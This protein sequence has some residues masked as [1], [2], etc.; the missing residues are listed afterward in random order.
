MATGSCVKILS[1][2]DGDGQYEKTSVFADEL[3]FPTGIMPWRKGA[4]IAAAPDIIYAEDTDGDGRADVQTVLFTGFTPGNQ[5]HRFNGFEWGL[6]GWIYVANGDSGGNV[7][8]VKTGQTVSINGRDVRFRPDTGEVETVSAMTQYGLRRDDWG[9]WFGND[10]PV[11]LWHVTLPE[12]YLKRNPK[13]AVKRVKQP[14]A[15]YEN[16]TRVFPVSQAMERPNQPWSL[17]H[18]TSACSPSPYRDDLFGNA[19]SDSVFIGEPVHN[20][21]H[22]EVLL[23]HGSG[24]R[25]HRASG[26]EAKE[27]LASTDNWFRPVFLRTGP[28]GALWVADFYRFVLEHPEWISA[29]MQSRMDLRAGSDKG[30][31]YRISPVGAE[32][33]RT[34]NLAGM[35]T[36]ALARAINSSNGWQR[37]MAQ[38]L[39]LERNDAA[40]LGPLAEMLAPTC[41]PQVRIQALATLGGLELLDDALLRQALADPHPWVRREA[42]RQTEREHRESLF[43]AVSALA[44]DADPAV[45]LQTAFTLGFWPGERSE[46]VLA[47]LATE[48]DETLRAAVMSSLSPES[49]LFKRLQQKESLPVHS[50]LP[51][52]KPS[53]PDREKV[54]ASYAG[55]AK[56][57]A[58]ATNGKLL[59]TTICATCH[60]LRGSGSEVGPDLGM[61]GNKPLEWMLAAILD[62]AQSVEAR[63]RGWTVT[64]NQGTV[65]SG[66]ISA[67]TANNLVLRMPGGQEQAILRSEIKSMSAISGSLMPTGFE[68]AL[69]PQ[70]LADVLQWIRGPQP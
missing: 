15:N 34:P 23:R 6:D 67:E 65:L 2:L 64:T 27:F 66:V 52:V 44:R 33:R 4:L 60:Q 14:L 57:K 42:M 63:Y 56:L 16:S 5:Q 51:T 13:L 21:V 20:A 48:D 31:I 46:A 59:F 41:A 68:S 25:S 24:F 38:R 9:N 29:E 47:E 22:R 28:D 30:R 45:R 3:P 1:D 54:I 32:R 39:L 8:S 40:A 18:V 61:T 49:A 10:N 26:E 11:W 69:T 50:V 58:D 53:S 37:D 19:F 55:V 17:N 35:D 36:A 70:Q 12:R 43:P 62:P 7:K